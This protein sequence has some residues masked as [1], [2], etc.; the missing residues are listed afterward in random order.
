MNMK[1]L[2]AVLIIE[3]SN[4]QILH[5]K[6]KG[7]GFDR[8]HARVTN[9]Y[10][11]TIST[12]I[13]DIAELGMRLN[14]NP[15]NYLDTYRVAKAACPDIE[16]LDAEKFYSG[17]EVF[18]KIDTILSTIL[19]CT[20]KVLQ[21]SEIQYIIE[22]VGIKSFLEGFYDKYDKEYRFLNNRRQG[23]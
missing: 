7:Q 5:W 21:E 23:D 11:E 15:V 12:D 9:D 13:D 6:V 10:Y 18:S 1:E 17:D 2:L 14:I 22:N 19:D 16:I 4:F 8:V 3:R 20:K